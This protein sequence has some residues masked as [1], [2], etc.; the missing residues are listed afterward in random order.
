LWIWFWLAVGNYLYQALGQHHWIDAFSST[1][2][3]GVFVIALWLT[4]WDAR[5]SLSR[6][7]RQ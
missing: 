1:F 2:D 7:E 3:Q 4:G 6:Q 5:R